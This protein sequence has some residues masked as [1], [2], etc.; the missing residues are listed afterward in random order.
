MFESKDAEYDVTTAVKQ[1]LETEKKKQ[2]TRDSRIR[3]HTKK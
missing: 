1:I 2:E 3:S